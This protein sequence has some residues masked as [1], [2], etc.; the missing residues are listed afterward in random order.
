M[1]FGKL[2]T[3]TSVFKSLLCI[4][5]E[6][7]EASMQSLVLPLNLQAGSEGLVRTSSHKPESMVQ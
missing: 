7:I 6:S 3:V 5:A 4:T 2:P 1:G